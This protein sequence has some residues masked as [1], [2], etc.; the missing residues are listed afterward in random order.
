[1]KVIA[2]LT[3][4]HTPICHGLSEHEIPA[5]SAPGLP[6]SYG[7]PEALWGSKNLLNRR[8]WAGETAYGWLLCEPP[9]DP[10]LYLSQGDM[11]CCGT[12][13][14]FNCWDPSQATGPVRETK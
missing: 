5:L 10:Y 11:H 6:L 12:L 14:T 8:S 7:W 2:L 3:S 1:M 4:L 9:R 13:L